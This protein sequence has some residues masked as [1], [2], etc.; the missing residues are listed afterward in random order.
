MFRRAAT[1]LVLATALALGAVLAHAQKATTVQKTEVNVGVLAYLGPDEAASAWEPT[2]AQ[3]NAALP[4]YHFSMVAGSQAFL[5]AA[6]AA[7]R[8][9]FLVTN[10]GHFLELKVDYSASA[11]ATE[12]DLDGFSS[13]ESVG[14]AI[15]VLDRRRELQQL[16]DL[17]GLKIAAVAPDA[18]GFRAAS[19]EMLEH[20]LDP[21]RDAIP[22]FTGF[23]ANDVLTV[24]RAGNAEA[25]VV[26]SCL[27]EKMIAEGRAGPDEFRV[28]G[29]KSGYAG[30]C[31]VSTR[32]YPGW[33]FVKV[34][35]TPKL[36]AGRSRASCSPCNRARA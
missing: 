22:V 6:V 29:R 2:L 7:H 17:R 34:S 13:S 21:L 30:K 24:L 9:D 25:G 14:A 5:T 16:A 10:P 11:L 12:Q 8:L 36:L 18:F 23:P 31:Q 27:L 20:G 15:V 28:L 4:A 1:F 19:G 35:Q 33:A 32:L 3:L 26:R